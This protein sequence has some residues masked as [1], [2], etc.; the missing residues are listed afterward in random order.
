MF[1]LVT[2]RGEGTKAGPSAVAEHDPFYSSETTETVWHVIT[3][4]LAPMVIGRD[5]CASQRDVW[6][7]MA[8]VRGHLMAKAASR[9]RRGTCTPSRRPAAVAGAGRQAPAVASGV[10]IGIQDSLDE[11]VER[12]SI[13]REA[14]YQRIKIKIKP[15]WDVKAVER[16]RGALA[17][18]R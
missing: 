12:V 4:F 6:P 2:V 13:E 10:S 8:R 18:S 15:G 3:G 14:G 7:A 9:W 16:V 11:L 17:T 5:V 1:L